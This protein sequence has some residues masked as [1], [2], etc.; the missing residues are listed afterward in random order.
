M[1]VCCFCAC[2]VCFGK[3]HSRKLLACQECGG[4][5][6]Q[7]CLDP[8]LKTVPK[9]WSCPDCRKSTRRGSPGEKRPVGR[10]RRFSPTDMTPL[11]PRK[12]G[13]PRLDQS[14]SPASKK[15]RL[16][17]GNTPEEVKVSRSGRP[18][19]RSTFHDEIEEGDQHLKTNRL[20]TFR[21]KPKTPASQK[22]K[23]ST[24]STKGTLT[25]SSTSSAQRKP[26][27]S[28]PTPK[29]T[30]VLQGNSPLKTPEILKGK[31]SFSSPTA[32]NAAPGSIPVAPLVNTSVSPDPLVNA[33]THKIVPPAPKPPPAKPPAAPVTATPAP[34]ATAAGTKMTDS[35]S[36][37]PVPSAATT[38]AQS[39]EKTPRRKPGAR[40]CVQISRR[41]GVRVIPETYM[42]IL[43]DYCQRGKVDHLIRMRERLD[44]HSRF[45]ELQLA[46][47]ES[48]VK[49]NGESDVVV[50]AI[51]P[52]P[53]KK[54]ERTMGIDPS[55]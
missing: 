28:A 41:F 12:R 3:R 13:R 39:N 31:P 37:S 26:N 49:K 43:T 40:E 27:P 22:A 51:P 34:A 21:P 17:S 14:S 2:R 9:S 35:N 23:S 5:Y 8:Q 30:P 25:S 55:E 20:A 4:R 11:V 44:D 48:L 6:H 38:A 50:P 53:D 19:K 54:L 45:L 46:T 29:A 1:T 7:Y 47:L 24:T 33:V 10:P 52:G 18:V 32:P 36:S 15:G 42:E 16:G